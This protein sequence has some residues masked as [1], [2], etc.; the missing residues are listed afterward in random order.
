MCE[1][2][3]GDALFPSGANR[4]SAAT[5]MTARPTTSF[6]IAAPLSRETE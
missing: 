2:S 1:A 3:A 5:A 4:A 6:F